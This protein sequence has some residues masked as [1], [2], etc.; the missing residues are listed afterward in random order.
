MNEETKRID[1]VI[2]RTLAKAREGRS[3][4]HSTPES[5]RRG[6]EFMV[7]ARLGS[8]NNL[9]DRIKRGEFVTSGQL[10]AAWLVKR[11]TISNAVSASRLFSVVGPAGETY[12]PAF[13]TDPLL[14]RR[15]LGKVAQTLGSLPSASKYHFFISKFTS[16]GESPLE[17]LRKG[18]VKH[19]LAAAACYAERGI[20]EREST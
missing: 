16:L 12:Y 7:Q 15:A 20:D 2:E 8:A 17:A 4:V 6:E 3:P 13:Y 14:A 1:A 9:A 18:R 5:I 11:A 19:V 10:Q